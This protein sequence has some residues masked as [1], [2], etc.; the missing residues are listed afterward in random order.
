MIAG[1]GSALL[2]KN[3]KERKE[4]KRVMQNKKVAGKGVLYV[5][6]LIRTPR[7]PAQPSALASVEE[8]RPRERAAERASPHTLMGMKSSFF[9]FYRLQRV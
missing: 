4:A 7:R 3:L 8:G 6:T 1:V 9:F 2:I 5:S